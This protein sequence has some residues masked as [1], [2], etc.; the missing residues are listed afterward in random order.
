[1]GSDG[2]VGANKNSIKIIG[3]A[4]DLY[5]QAY[6]VYDSKKSGGL[7]QSHLRFGKTP[8]RSPYLV[9]AADFVACHTPSYVHKYDMVK[10]LKEGGTFLLNCPW[11]L[12]GLE[13]NL[14]ASMKRALAEKHAKLYTI[15]AISIARKLGLGS[16]TNTILQAAFFTL[17]G[18][19]P[20]DQAVAEMK[21]AIYKAYYKKKG[22]AVVDMN[23]A[24]IDHGINELV[25]C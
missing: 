18:V 5:C 25:C 22:Q 24:S 15:D 10:D 23:N 3:H 9:T 14:P 12:E 8:I 11:D 21:D 13:K 6:F 7:T 19:I 1:M 2:T 4:T 17:T 20:I 16:R